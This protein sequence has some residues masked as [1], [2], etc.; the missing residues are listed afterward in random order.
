MNE[1]ECLAAGLDPKAVLK[2][3][4]ALNRAGKLA[5]S[6]GVTIFGGSGR[7]TLRIHDGPGV[8]NGS[9]ILAILEC[10]VWDGGDGACCEDEEGLLRGE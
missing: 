4:R 2:L 9:L 10:H 7:G 3:E 5:E 6:L 1:R 8:D